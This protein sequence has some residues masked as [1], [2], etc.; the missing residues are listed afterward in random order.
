MQQVIKALK[1]R[2][3]YATESPMEARVVNEL[4]EYDGIGFTTQYKVEPYRLDVAV[5]PYKLALEIDGREW[6]SSTQQK[7]KD[8]LKDAYLESKG[9]TVERVPAWLCYQAP[10]MAVLKLLRHYPDIKKWDR[11]PGMA[12]PVYLKTKTR[13]MKTKDYDA[14]MAATA[15]SPTAAMPFAPPFAQSMMMPY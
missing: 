1:A 7:A 3:T 2:R 9:W 8:A 5:L 14:M 6:H 10:E 13:R 4:L 15:L 11:Y 12:S